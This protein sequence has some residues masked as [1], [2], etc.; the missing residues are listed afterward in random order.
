[1][2]FEGSAL[3]TTTVFLPLVGALLIIFLLQGDKEVRCFAGFVALAELALS[4]VVFFRYDPE[5][6]Q[7]Q[8]V[9]RVAGWIPVES[10]KVDYFLAVDGLS[11]ARVA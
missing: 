6:P 7:Y 8:L 10:F 11:D 1:M 5:G 4:V 9:D 2:E 3:L